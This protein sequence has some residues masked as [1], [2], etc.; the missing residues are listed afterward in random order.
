ME[1]KPKAKDNIHIAI[2]LLLSILQNITLTDLQHSRFPNQVT[3]S[4]AIINKLRKV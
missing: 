1:N 4:R 2:T 3:H